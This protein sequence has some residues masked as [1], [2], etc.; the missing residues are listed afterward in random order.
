MERQAE[1]EEVAQALGHIYLDW[2]TVFGDLD[3]GAFMLPN[4]GGRR[5]ADHIADNV[6]VVT[7][8]ELLWAGSALEGDLFC[9]KTRHRHMHYTSL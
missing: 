6:G 7:F 2:L 4:D 5:R 1:G 9:R 8:V 3:P